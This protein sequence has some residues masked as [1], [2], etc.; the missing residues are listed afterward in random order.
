MAETQR[1]EPVAKPWK[2]WLRWGAIVLVIGILVAEGIFLWPELSKAWDRVGDIRWWWVLAAFAVAVFEMDSYA[3]VQRVLFRSAGVK[4]KERESLALVLASNSISQTMPGGQVLA[5]AFVYR[6]TRKWGATPV[7]A[8]WQLVM[9][10]L[11]AGVGLAVLGLG[12]TLLAGAQTNPFS[13][14]FSIAG[15]IAFVAVAQFL[16]SNPEIV[17]SLGNRALD[18]INDF[19]G[20]PH[21]HGRAR[22]RRIVGQ[23]R[24]VKLR[25]RDAAQAFVWSLLNWV[26]DILCLAFACYAVGAHP[27]FAGLMVAFAAGKAV[28]TAVPIIPGGLG[29]VDVVLVPA[30]VSAGMPLSDAFLAVVVYRLVSFIMISIVGW[31]VIAVR[32]RGA[33][34]E[35]DEIRGEMEREEEVHS[36]PGA[37][38][39]IAGD[40][41]KVIEKKPATPATKPKKT[42][43]EKPAKKASGHRPKKSGTDKDA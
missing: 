14:F 2:K 10:G 40:D 20:K 38:A 34:S 39:E 19:R 33:L 25:R 22:W 17:E 7:V 12:G 13:I 16:A 8:S 9:S 31:I 11:L 4:V 29:V 21:T 5:P 24:A 23:L 43:S 26:A 3:E 36:T 1:D 35:R 6:E 18:K 32:Y 41:G 37:I 15:F 42:P 27:G 28:G 30:L